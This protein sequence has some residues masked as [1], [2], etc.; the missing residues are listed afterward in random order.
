MLLADDPPQNVT[1]FSGHMIDAPDRRT[2]RFP[3]EMEPIAASAIAATLA[4]IGAVAGDLAICGGACG[5][6]LLFAE[7]CL[8]KGMRLEIYL[9]QDEATFLANSVDFAGGNWRNRY[10]AVKAKA[11]LH[12]A[13]DELGPLGEGQNAYERNNQWMLKSAA[14]FGGERMAF[15]SLWNGEGGD[16]PGGAKHLMDEARY[17]TSRIYWLDTRKL[18]D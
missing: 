3:P 6:D 7:A 14:R 8:A 18:L 9:P 1:L 11:T 12:I 10:L 2:P 15:I 17:K 4:E 13:P 16:G 5:G